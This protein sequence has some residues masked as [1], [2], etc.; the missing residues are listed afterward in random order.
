MKP[1]TL[2]PLQQ[3]I[4]ESAHA[5]ICKDAMSFMQ[6]AWV[7]WAGIASWNPG[8]GVRQGPV[9]HLRDWLSRKEPLQEAAEKCRVCPEGAVYLACAL[10]PEAT[11]FDAFAV[12]TH[13]QSKLPLM[14]PEVLKKRGVSGRVRRKFTSVADFNDESGLDPET[15][16][17]ILFE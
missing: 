1:G 6:C 11:N 7:Q 17:K 16:I 3:Q 4:L 13:L 2:T 12:I 5:L 9:Q 14:S 15:I 8:Y 10:N